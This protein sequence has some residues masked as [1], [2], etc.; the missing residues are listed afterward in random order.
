MT[1]AALSAALAEANLA[2]LLSAV[3]H[4]TGDLT[5]LDRFGDRRAF[6]HGRGP[7]TLPDDVADAIRAEASSRLTGHASD[8]PADAPSLDARSLHRIMEF[9]AGEEVP[10]DYVA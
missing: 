1:A 5:L 6:D 7:A 10:A 3:A 4:L 8:G 2:V 9:C